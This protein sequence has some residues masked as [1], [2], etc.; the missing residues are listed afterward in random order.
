M[1]SRPGSVR[2]GRTPPDVPI[3][4]G[5]CDLVASLFGVLHGDLIASGRVEYGERVSEATASAM[6]A[7]HRAIYS[8]KL[9]AFSGSRCGRAAL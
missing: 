7:I 3:G 8:A 4:D 1:E 2:R 9:G 6:R 5:T